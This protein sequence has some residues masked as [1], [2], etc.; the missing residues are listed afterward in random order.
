MTI[1]LWV[2]MVLIPELTLTCV[3]LRW[4]PVRRERWIAAMPFPVTAVLA[5][6]VRFIAETSWPT[7]LATCAG[8]L[9]GVVVA[10]VPFRGWL[11]SWTLPQ[12]GEARLRWH[13]GALAMVGA[14]TPLPVQGTD[15]ALEKAFAVR[16]VVRARGRFPL[17]MGV[18]LLAVPA[19][20]AVGAGWA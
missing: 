13:E 11:S 14:I 1:P 20:C 3:L 7:A 10:L 5:L 15:A 19:T 12:Q 6:A 2:L 4:L 9:W 18:A 17:L 8:F 16:Q